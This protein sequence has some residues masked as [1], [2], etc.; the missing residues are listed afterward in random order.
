RGN[1]IS[2]GAD[3]AVWRAV[4]VHA[5]DGW[6]TAARRRL[7]DPG[8]C[9][10]AAARR[11]PGELR[12]PLCHGRAIDTGSTG[13]RCWRDGEGDSKAL[14][15][16]RGVISAADGPHQRARRPRVLR[17]CAG[18]AVMRE[19]TPDVVFRGSWG[20]KMTP[21]VWCAVV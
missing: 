5:R 13:H 18:D 15:R 6:R 8:V 10:G 14:L 2:E 7:D 20:K 12:G 21:R 16:R 9:A 17:P 4:L 11:W 3:H 19:T 1:A